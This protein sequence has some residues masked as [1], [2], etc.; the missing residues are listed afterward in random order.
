[1][2][3]YNKLLLSARNKWIANVIAFNHRVVALWYAPGSIHIFTTG[4]GD[5]SKEFE[6]RPAKAHQRIERNPRRCARSSSQRRR[7][8]TVPLTARIASRAVCHI[9]WP[10]NLI[11]WTAQLDPPS[12]RAAD[13]RVQPLRADLTIEI[14]LT[15][16]DLPGSVA[17]VV[18]IAGG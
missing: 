11:A 10:P 5:L 17:S 2:A 16:S 4:L 18:S 7:K 1:M 12:H 13:M 15:N 14:V 9:R 3:E 6:G 8:I